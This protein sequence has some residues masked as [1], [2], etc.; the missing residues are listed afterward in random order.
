MIRVFLAYLG[1]IAAYVLGFFVGGAA[2]V[3]TS[4]IAIWTPAG[5]D[6]IVGLTGS[7]LAANMFAWGAFAG[8]LKKERTAAVVGFSVLLI[9][10]AVLYAAGALVD[11]DLRLLWY[12]VLSV[13]MNVALP[14]S[15]IRAARKK[16]RP[17]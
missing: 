5:D 4:A 17:E 1:G 8:I 7:A 10:F 2:G 9:G 14:V 16:T 13:G 12:P 15:A 6:L 3:L 11:G